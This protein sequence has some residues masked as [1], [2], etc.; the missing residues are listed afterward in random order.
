VDARLLTRCTNAGL[1]TIVGMTVSHLSMPFRPGAS[2]GA[3]LGF[4]VALAA[5][6]GFAGWRERREAG[7]ADAEVR[8]PAGA[9]VAGGAAVALLAG[10]VAWAAVHR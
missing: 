4:G 9:W 5:A 8:Y 6:G 7:F 3:R 2:W 1:V 10:A